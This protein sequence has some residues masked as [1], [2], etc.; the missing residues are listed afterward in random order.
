M[1][2]TPY[3]TLNAKTAPAPVSRSE[4]DC[5]MGRPLFADLGLDLARADARS[6]EHSQSVDRSHDCGDIGQAPCVSDLV[7]KHGE[8]G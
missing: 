5:V 2:I 6:D 4:G 1:H 7:D 3:V 8:G